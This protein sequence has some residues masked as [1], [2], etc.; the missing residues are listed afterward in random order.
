[1]LIS[2]VFLKRFGLDFRQNL[3][4]S[5]PVLSEMPLSFFLGGH[6]VYLM[7]FVSTVQ[8]KY[9]RILQNLH[10]PTVLFQIY[11]LYSTP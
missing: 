6:P 5:L 4:L 7:F 9:R 10:F 11:L 2:Y 3:Q 8:I 1:M